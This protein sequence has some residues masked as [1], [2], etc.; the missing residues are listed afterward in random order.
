MN[1]SMSLE[2]YQNWEGYGLK[3][4]DVHFT[5]PTFEFNFR[6]VFPRANKAVK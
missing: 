4:R 5:V 2:K 3:R 6:I 1:I